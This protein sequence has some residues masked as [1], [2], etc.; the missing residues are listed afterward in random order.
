MFEKIN[1]NI[2]IQY[3]ILLLTIMSIIFGCLIYYFRIQI[4]I[5]FFQSNKNIRKNTNGSN[6][7]DIQKN[8]KLIN[9]ITNDITSDIASDIASENVSKKPNKKCYNNLPWDNEVKPDQKIIC[10]Y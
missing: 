2:K 9:N 7:F 3:K 4:S 8:T 10:I 1:P 5:L 6:N